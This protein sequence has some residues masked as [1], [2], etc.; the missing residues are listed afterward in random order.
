MYSICFCVSFALLNHFFL[1]TVKERENSSDSGF[2]DSPNSPTK[3]HTEKSNSPPKILT[4]RERRERRVN[5]RRL[6]NMTV[7]LGVPDKRKDNKDEDDL[8]R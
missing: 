2:E 7:N 3:L 5:E 1:P 6:T 8:Y 4:S